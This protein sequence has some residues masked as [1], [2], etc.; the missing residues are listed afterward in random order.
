MG[1]VKAV[2]KVVVARCYPPIRLAHALGRIA[3]FVD[4][5]FDKDRETA[6]AACMDLRR[7]YAFRLALDLCFSG[8]SRTLR[9]TSGHPNLLRLPV[10]FGVV[11]AKPGEAKDH[12]LLAQRGD[13][14]LGSL[15]M[16]FVAQ[17]D[18]CDFGDRTCFVGSSIDIVDGDGSGEAMGGNIVR[19]DILCVDKQAG[20]TA[21]DKCTCVVLHCGVRGLN[22]DVDV[23]R[24]F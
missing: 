13:C 14:E 8:A 10:D 19:T 5:L 22:F 12:G 24:V 4:D 18:V 16:P 23:E 20:G 21:V 11:F 9:W 7:C 17:Y 2:V 6:S 3:V 15:C 1:S